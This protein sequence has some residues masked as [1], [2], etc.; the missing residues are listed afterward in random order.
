ML[1]KV[2][3]DTGREFPQDALNILTLA[4]HFNDNSN[5]ISVNSLNSK[6][7]F[8]SPNEYSDSSGFIFKITGEKLGFESISV[9]LYQN[10]PIMSNILKI[11]VFILKV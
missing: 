3:D 4:L 7:W 8:I 11:E 1:V 2:Y 6:E 10:T 5:V 9:K